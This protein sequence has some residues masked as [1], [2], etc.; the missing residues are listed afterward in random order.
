M[1]FPFQ[2]KGLRSRTTVGFEPFGCRSLLIIRLRLPDI[3]K[4]RQAQ[5][6]QVECPH[7]CH[8]PRDFIAD[9]ASRDF[10]GTGDQDFRENA[11]P[12]HVLRIHGIEAIS[13]RAHQE[14]AVGH[15]FGED[16]ARERKTGGAFR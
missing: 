14:P 16:F 12:P 4:L 8:A 11:R 10:S 13:S 2:I 15:A 9:A 1:N 6:N 5:G 7:F 3:P